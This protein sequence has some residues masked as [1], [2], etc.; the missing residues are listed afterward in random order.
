MMM[1]ERMRLRDFALGESKPDRVIEVEYRPT[2]HWNGRS[3]AYEVALDGE[4]I[5]K[6]ER[7]TEST[8]RHY[9][10]IRIPGKGRPAWSWRG[11]D[12][13]ANSPGLYPHNRRGA[14]AKI[15]GYSTAERIS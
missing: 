4:V 12:G 5:G 14:V 11:A 7:A 1:R 8:D 6:I 15:L 13:R 10:R 9:G 2:R 3:A